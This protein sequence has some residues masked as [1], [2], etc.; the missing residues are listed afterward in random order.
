MKTIKHL[1]VIACI[2]MPAMGFAQLI[3]S[4]THIDRVVAWKDYCEIRAGYANGAASYRVNDTKENFAMHGFSF[5]MMYNI[6]L[7]KKE[8]PLYLGV[9]FSMVGYF[10]SH[11]FFGQKYSMQNLTYGVPAVQFRYMFRVNESVDISPRVGADLRLNFVANCTTGG[12][13]YNLLADKQNHQ[14]YPFR[15][16]HKGNVVQPGVS[17]GVD[18]YFGAFSVGWGLR[19][20]I[21]PIFDAPT[22]EKISGIQNTINVGCRF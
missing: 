3:N 14:V 19:K 13:T 4:S 17:V 11:N 16:G 15:T 7:A 6:N 12:T 1:L 5:D 9:G 10:G 22:G 20:S 21:I 2:C 8:K 18:A